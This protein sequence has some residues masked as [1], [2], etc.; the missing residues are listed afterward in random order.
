MK[1][2]FGFLVIFVVV[3]LI[4]FGAVRLLGS[5]APKEGELRV[6]ATPTVSVFLDN[7]H[8]GRTPLREKVTAGEY[9]IRLVAESTTG[10]IAPWQAKIS[11]G[12]NLLTYVNAVLS[13]SE[14][15]SAVDVLWLEK[16][17]VG[18]PELS[19]ITNPDGASV[20]LDDVTKGITP[21]TISDMT[22]GDHMLTVTSPGFLTRTMK[23][24]LTAGYK[25]IASM[26]LALSAGGVPQPEA[27][28]AATTL[29]TPTLKS[30]AAATS[31][32]TPQKPYVLIKDTPTGFLRVRME[33][34][35]AATEAGR[36]N[37]GEK[38]HLFNQ[39]TGWYQISHD[40]TN[41]GWISAQYA[42]KV[43]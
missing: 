16:S 21:L 40:G 2:K 8:I 1:R 38:Y 39:Q 20:V 17:V 28:P 18:K 37:P 22:A 7:K 9:T 43:E 5:R 35:T 24:K 32:A 42:D 12:A 33:P 11:V 4:I 34:S 41:K 19:V 14:L 25:L 6:D 13:E 26:K 10:E 23:V 3:T 31:S 36:V 30:G 27:T 29:T 15:S